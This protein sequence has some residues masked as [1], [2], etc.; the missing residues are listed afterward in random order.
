[1]WKDSQWQVPH[2]SVFVF[3]P[4]ETKKWTSH[5]SKLNMHPSTRART[6]MKFYVIKLHGPE[7]RKITKGK[8]YVNMISHHR[9]HY[10]VNVMRT[11]LFQRD[12]LCYTT[13]THKMTYQIVMVYHIT[14]QYNIVS[15]YN[16]LYWIEL[17]CIILDWM[18]MHCACFSCTV[19]ASKRSPDV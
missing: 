12:L 3:F 11:N 5:S 14:I 4:T 15:Y 2:S 10:R 7:N 16:T 13:I 17:N 1:M 18:L 9:N 19:T 6:V 8:Y